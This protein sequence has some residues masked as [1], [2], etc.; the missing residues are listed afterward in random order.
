[1]LIDM[2]KLV[3]P[4]VLLCSFGNNIFIVKETKVFI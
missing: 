1:M 3:I 4:I 2:L